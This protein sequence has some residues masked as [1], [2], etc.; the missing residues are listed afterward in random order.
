MESETNGRW[1][2]LAQLASVEYDHEKLLALIK[3]INRLL[4]EE[5]KRIRLTLKS[6]ESNLEK[7]DQHRRANARLSC[8]R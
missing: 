8:L 3:E 6:A 1:F 2:Q 4:D 5:E 7:M